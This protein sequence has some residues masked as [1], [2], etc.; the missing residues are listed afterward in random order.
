MVLR[1]C[2]N[3]KKNKGAPAKHCGLMI[4]NVFPLLI[5]HGF[6]FNTFLPQSENMF[7]LLG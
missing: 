3:G 7:S 6:L 2:K 4:V 1:L 5:K